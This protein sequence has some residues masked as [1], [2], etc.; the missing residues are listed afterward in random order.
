MTVSRHSPIDSMDDENVDALAALQTN[1]GLSEHVRLRGMTTCP[2]CHLGFG[3]T[4]LPI[5]VRRCRAL[6]PPT[7]EE[8]VAANT[9]QCQ[10]VHSR[11]RKEVRSLVDLCLRFVTRHFESVC[12]ERIVAFPEAEAALIA[13]M[14]SNLVHRMVINLVKESK[15]I[16]AKDREGRATIETLESALQGARRDVAQ[17]ESARDWAAIS[18]SRMA[19]QQHV[20]D[21]LQRELDTTK[22]A[23]ASAEVENQKLRAKTEAAGEK[24]L[25]LEA[26]INTLN[27]EKAAL[28]KASTEAQRR[29]MEATRQLAL[30]TKTAKTRSC[31]ARPN[32]RRTGYYRDRSHSLSSHDGNGSSRDGSLNRKAFATQSSLLLY[33]ARPQADG[34]KIPYPKISNTRA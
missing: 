8:E 11:R 2:H 23:L 17:L 10:P 19:E 20:A 32:S 3:R 9:E 21:R 7:V 1:G 4:S 16:K 22:L 28:K 24:L 30:A 33:H 18:R 25:R 26:K 27:A 15:R 12:M 34:S 5:H 29:E 14:P 13:S 31:T 6:L